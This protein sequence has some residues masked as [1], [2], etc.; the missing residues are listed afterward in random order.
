ME[1][2]IV[3]ASQTGTAQEYA[4][5]TAKELWTRGYNVILVDVKQVSLN[6]LTQSKSI[7]VFLISTCGQGDL[8]CSANS[9]WKQLLN[10]SLSR[11]TL[12]EGR[13]RFAIFGLGDSSYEHFNYAAKKMYR[14]LEQLG[15]CFLTSPSFA[16]EQSSRGLDDGFDVWIRSL[17]SGIALLDIA[18]KDNRPTQDM[19]KIQV[20]DNHQSI[21]VPELNGVVLMNHR[22]T[23]PETFEKDVRLIRIGVEEEEGGLGRLPGDV[24][25]LYPQSQDSD[26]ALLCRRLHWDPSIVYT[27]DPQRP[28][29]TLSCFSCSLFDLLKYYLDIYSYPKK[30]FFA[31]LSTYSGVQDEAEKLLEIANQDHDLYLDYCVRPKRSPLEVLDDFMS[32]QCMPMQL[33]FELFPLIRPRSFSIASYNEH[34]VDIAIALVRYK[35]KWIVKEREGLASRFLS[36]IKVGHGVRLEVIP[37]DISVGSKSLKDFD[38]VVLIGA[39]TGIAPLRSIIQ[40]IEKQKLD[41][42]IHL[43]Y[44]CRY[45][46]NDCLFSDEFK[47]SSCVQYHT[48]GSRDRGNH[49]QPRQHID[50]LLKQNCNLLK[51]LLVEGSKSVVFLSGN[52]HLPKLV[53]SCIDGIVGVVGFADFLHQ[54][55]RFYYECWS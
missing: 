20:N 15:G 32:V 24:A 30:S 39:G 23:T 53:K 54:H 46:Q 2:N 8:P 13:Q 18:R 3:F 1:I 6:M 21:T 33:V 16:D 44:G 26:V 19:Y 25:V 51:Q 50:V 43:F 48:L 28:D 52:N 36:R 37:G 4:S 22:L 12:A 10:A 14:R 34:Y 47:A 11:K 38:N 41:V 55:G 42:P 35:T 17:V 9:L 45:L 31:I 49:A 27:F 7:W 40:F 5:Q 29:A